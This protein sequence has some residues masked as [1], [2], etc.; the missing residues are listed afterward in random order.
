[1]EYKICYATREMIPAC[2]HI[3]QV[4]FEDDEAY[5]ELYFTHRF[6]EDNMLVCCVDKEPVSMISLLPAVLQQGKKEIPLRYVYA[7]ATLPAYRRRG[8]A[9]ILMKKARQLF[10]EVLVL[11]PASSHLEEYYKKLG[12]SPAFAVSERCFSTQQ[13]QEVKGEANGQEYWLLTVTPSEYVKLRDGY[14]AGDGY[15]RWDEEAIYY[16]LLENDFAD[17]YAYK[18]KHHGREDILLLR[19]T[20]KRIHVIET[21]LTD[22]KLLAVMKRLR[23][24]KDLLVR[25]PAAAYLKEQSSVH[26]IS[27]CV[28]RTFGMMDTEGMH[29][30]KLDTAGSIIQGY[31]NLTLE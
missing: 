16:A 26:A 19:E 1:M 9:E 11:E 18:V 10:A 6:T 28:N 8:Y 15:V 20:E 14:F 13:I 12:F 7:V 4:C 31:L 23:V 25:R 3:W 24:K 21:T 17:G 2:R 29:R 5:T 30:Y 22:A 27:E